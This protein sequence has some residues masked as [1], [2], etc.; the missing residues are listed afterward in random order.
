MNEALSIWPDFGIEHG[1][2]EH[3]LADALREATM[4]LAQ[5]SASD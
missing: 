2:F 1:V 5:A 4:H 3:R